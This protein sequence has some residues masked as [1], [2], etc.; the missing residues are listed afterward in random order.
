[1][2][3]SLGLREYIA[4]LAEA[5][6][7]PASK[8]IQLTQLGSARASVINDGVGWQAAIVAF[9][10]TFAVACATVLFLARARRGWQ[11]SALAERT[12]TG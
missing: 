6:E 10:L 9:L 5:R 2:G 7:T 4:G 3:P 8:Q 12:A 1:M 11:V